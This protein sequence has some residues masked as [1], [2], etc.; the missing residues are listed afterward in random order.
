MLHS[1]VTWLKYI[2]KLETLYKTYWLKSQFW[3]IWG[4]RGQKFIFTKNASP[5]TIYIVWSCDLGGHHFLWN[6]GVMNF[7]KYL[8]N[9]FV[10]P[11]IWR[12]KILW[13]PP[14]GATMLKKHVTPNARS[15]ENM[16]FFVLFHW[17]KFSSKFVAI[18]KSLDF[19][20]TPLFLMKK[21]CDPPSFF[22]APPIRKKMITPYAYK[23]AWDPLQNSLTQISIWGHL[24][25][26]VSKGYFHKSDI[27]RPCYIA[28]LQDS[29]ICISLRPSTYVVGQG[30]TRCHPES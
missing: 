1:R 16:H 24:G 19:F 6:R 17:T 7:R 27:T 9:I 12:S 26:H 10:T 29:C 18:Q 20:V 25:S 13:P 4:H 3:V 2:I 11:P 14:F 5:H 30:S 15:A 28:W 21:F 23:Q 22:M 8:G